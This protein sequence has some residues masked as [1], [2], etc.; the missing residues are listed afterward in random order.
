ML[1]CSSATFCSILWSRCL[2][3]VEPDTEHGVSLE[4]LHQGDLIDHGP[5]ACV[6]K[7]SILLHDG[8]P[9]RVYQMVSGLV[10]HRMQTYLPRKPNETSKVNKR[11]KMMSEAIIV[12]L[13]DCTIQ[14]FFCVNSSGD[15]VN[16]YIIINTVL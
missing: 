4:V 1:N 13:I 11:I 2:K 6:H 5:S 12:R 16:I 9:L 14:L 10:Q 8:Q 15:Y 7:N 3:D